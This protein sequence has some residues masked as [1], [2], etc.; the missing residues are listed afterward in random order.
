[1]RGL[2]ILAPRL[3]FA[4]SDGG[5][6][7][8]AT[9]TENREI[10]LKNNG[11]GYEFCYYDMVSFYRAFSLCLM[12]AEDG[13]LDEIRVKPYFSRMG[14]MQCAEF[15]VINVKRSKSL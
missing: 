9:E 14:S 8:V 7:I 2:E 12:R 5:V 13:K 6:K 3:R 11:D 15:A 1:M 4:L 10:I